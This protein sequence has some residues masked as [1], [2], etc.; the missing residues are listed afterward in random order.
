MVWYLVFN[1]AQG[2]G[3]LSQLHGDLR[4]QDGVQVQVLCLLLLRHL[5]HV[6]TVGDHVAVDNLYKSYS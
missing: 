3:H 2:Q 4:R 6:L 1:G 5:V